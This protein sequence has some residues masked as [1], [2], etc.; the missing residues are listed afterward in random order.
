MP[1]MHRPEFK[2]VTVAECYKG[3]KLSKGVLPVSHLA[4]G[5]G[6]SNQ[7]INY[8]IT[9]PGTHPGIPHG[10]P[11]VHGSA[12]FHPTT[13]PSTTENP[14]PSSPL[15]IPDPDFEEFLR[16]AKIGPEAIKTRQALANEAVDSFRVF[17]KTQVYTHSELKSWGIPFVH[18]DR[19]ITSAPR[20]KA[21]L[22]SL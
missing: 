21:H 9:S 16:F 1:P 7:T 10:M 4:P 17:L 14:P 2:W 15:E 19:L 8:H 6:H 5:T 18:A 20:Y 22:K 12:F 3:E 13:Q 11:T